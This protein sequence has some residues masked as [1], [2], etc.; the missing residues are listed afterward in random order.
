MKI[1]ILCLAVGFALLVLAQEAESDAK[2]G[3]I[4]SAY[5]AEM[6]GFDLEENLKSCTHL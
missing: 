2:R 4:A 1:I 6:R 5:Q 3:C